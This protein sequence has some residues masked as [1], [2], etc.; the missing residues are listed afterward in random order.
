M[1]LSFIVT[2]SVITVSA[3]YAFN[4]K[5]LEYEVTQNDYAQ[6]STV[7]LQEEVEKLIQDD[8]LP[9]P[10]GVEL[11]KRWTKTQ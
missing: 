1:K 2:L 6:M 4:N 10:M 9:F 5:P 3:L 7:K 8:K 11:I